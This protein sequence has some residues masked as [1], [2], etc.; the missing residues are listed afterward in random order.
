MASYDNFGSSVSLLGDMDGD[1]DPDLFVGEVLIEPSPTD[2]HNGLS[3]SL[4]DVVEGMWA[5]HVQEQMNQLEASRVKMLCDVIR[6]TL[7]VIDRTSHL[8]TSEASL[9][10]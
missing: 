8:N 6:F 7:N 1:G 4:T 2:P 5:S 9:N 10:T 3:P